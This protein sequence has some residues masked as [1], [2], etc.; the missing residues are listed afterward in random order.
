MTPDEIT[1]AANALVTATQ[2]GAVASGQ[3]I[4]AGQE[5]LAPGLATGSNAPGGYNYERNVAP[6]V[7]AITANLVANA[8]QEVFRGALRDAMYGAEQNYSGAQS[9]YQQRQ[10]QFQL[11]QAE[12]AR[13]RQ[14]KADSDAAA[15]SAAAAALAGGGGRG[16]GNVNVS[17][18]EKQYIGNNDWRGYLNFLAQNKG[19]KNAAVALKYV[20]N[21][22]KYK[23]D[24]NVTNPAIIQALNAVGATN[25]WKSP[26]PI[27]GG[28]DAQ[29]PVPGT[30][31]LNAMG[32]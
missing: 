30:A 6:V 26:A 7:P 31:V 20:G 8:K 22:N 12:R 32:R 11:D 1:A 18:G 24:P 25:V 2:T 29:R 4:E 9:G 16:V 15:A 14:R 17:S 21:D 3:N 27:L 13:E 23:L 28:R 19:D 10:R 5:Q